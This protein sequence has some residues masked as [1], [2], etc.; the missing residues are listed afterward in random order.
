MIQGLCQ[1]NPIH[2]TLTI[3]TRQDKDIDHIYLV[4]CDITVGVL[5]FV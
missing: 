4:N 5:I 2:W 1:T 3:K